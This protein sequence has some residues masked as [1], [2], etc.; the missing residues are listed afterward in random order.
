MKT[1]PSP[2]PL[3][4]ICFLVL[5]CAGQ[6]C[7]GALGRTLTALKDTSSMSYLLIHP[8]HKVEAVCRD[9][10][11]SVVYDDASHTIDSASFSAGVSCFDSGNS[12]RDSHAMEVL[13]ALTFPEVSFRSREIRADGSRLSVAGDLTFH[14][15]TRSLTFPATADSGGGTL[16]VRG[17]AGISLTEFKIDRP[18][19]LMLPVEDTLRISFIVVFPLGSR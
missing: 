2:L 11:C 7:P 17:N 4:P 13:D 5:L 18:S 8:L 12:N 3:I 15:E 14:G 16:T 6:A 1:L 10:D 9:I 19:L